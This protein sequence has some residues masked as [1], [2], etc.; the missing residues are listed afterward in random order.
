MAEPHYNIEV[1]TL[2][3]DNNPVIH[4]EESGKDTKCNLWLF[5]SSSFNRVTFWSNTIV[6][7]FFPNGNFDSDIW[8]V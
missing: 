3:Q 8:L 5:S 6:E 1:Y 4:V 2:R 7:V